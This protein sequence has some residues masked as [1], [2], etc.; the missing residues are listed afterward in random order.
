MKA[1]ASHRQ[2]PLNKLLMFKVERKVSKLRGGLLCPPEFHFLWGNESSD[3]SIGATTT[4]SVRA[5]VASSW[6]LSKETE[7]IAWVP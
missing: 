6:T 7:L 4:S 5:A 3:S 1:N 2:A